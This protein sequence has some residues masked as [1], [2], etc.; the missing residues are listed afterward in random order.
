MCVCVCLSYLELYGLLLFLLLVTP[1]MASLLWDPEQS[2]VVIIR[3]LQ[4]CV[5][6]SGCPSFG[7][8]LNTDD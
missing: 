4:E 8:T 7:S 6:P 3:K 1:D 5:C 2:R